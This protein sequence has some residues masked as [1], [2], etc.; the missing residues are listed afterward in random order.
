MIAEDMSKNFDNEWECFLRDIYTYASHPP[1]KWTS[2]TLLSYFLVKYKAVNDLDFVFSHTK[3]G[4]T[5][6]K[7]MKDSARIWSMFDKGRYKK[8]SNKQEKLE[9]KRQLVSILQDYINWAF[10]VKFRS[11][12]ANV[13]G[14]GIFAVSNFMNEFL[15]W[16]KARKNALPKRSDKLPKDFTDWVA[17]NVPEVYNKQ[18]LEVLEDLNAL[19]NYIEQYDKEHKSIE[20]IVLKRSIEIGLMPKNGKLE[21][22]KK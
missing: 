12:Q 7:E 9:Y 2:L 16:R 4:P 5:T 17:K 18:Q 6:S 1:E 13:T 10:D 19:A 8:L 11:R 3:K 14:L 22:S 15:Q 21:L 20:A